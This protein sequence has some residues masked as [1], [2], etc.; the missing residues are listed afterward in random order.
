LSL[1]DPFL[2]TPNFTIVILIVNKKTYPKFSLKLSVGKNI[3]ADKPRER[4]IYIYTREKKRCSVYYL[5]ISIAYKRFFYRNVHTGH[6]IRRA[7]DEPDA[8]VPNSITVRLII[9]HHLHHHR[10]PHLGIYII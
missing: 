8:I 3:K 6:V 4:Y 2:F 10:N 1:L 7:M 5:F 9:Y